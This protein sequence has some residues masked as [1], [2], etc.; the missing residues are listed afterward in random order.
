MGSATYK[1][2]GGGQV[3]TDKYTVYTVY[4]GGARIL[5]REGNIGKNFINEFL[6][7]PV[8][9]RRRQNFGS[10]GDIQHKYTHQRLLKNFENIYKKFA[11]KFKKFSK[12]FSK[13]KLN[14][15]KENLSK[16]KKM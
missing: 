4:R 13:I 2:W 12:N 3:T 7:S 10:K 5:I 6:P 14:K 9:Q 8:L 11:P 1:I 15:I 16:V